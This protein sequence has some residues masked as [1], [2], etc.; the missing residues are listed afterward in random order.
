MPARL[1][2]RRHQRDGRCVI[3][4]AGAVDGST[5][6]H[7]LDVLARTPARAEGLVLDLSAVTRVEGF[8]LDVLGRGLRRLT[9]DRRLV[10]IEVSGPL[11]P[12]LAP[13]IEELLDGRLGSVAGSRAAQTSG[14]VQSLG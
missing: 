1:R 2:I 13:L 12:A 8:G 6:C 14:A 4:L 11:L 3:A 9:R 10:S 5:A 7:A